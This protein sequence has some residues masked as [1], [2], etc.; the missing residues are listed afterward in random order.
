MAVKVHISPHNFVFT[1]TNDLGDLAQEV[2]NCVF[3]LFSLLIVNCKSDRLMEELLHKKE[4]RLDDFEHF[5]SLWI[6]K[7][8]KIKKWLLGC[9]KNVIYR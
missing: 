1:N 9:Q 5:Q 2:F 3:S 6:A 7:H 4:P 8:A